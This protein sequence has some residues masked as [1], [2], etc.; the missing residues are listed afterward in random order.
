LGVCS[1]VLSVQLYKLPI[2][3]LVLYLEN[4][5]PMH[6]NYVTHLT[7]FFSSVV[8]LIINKFLFRVPGLMPGLVMGVFFSVYFATP[9]LFFILKYWEVLISPSSFFFTLAFVF[10]CPLIM[11]IVIKSNET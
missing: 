7:T 10:L 8:F 11:N 3:K 2:Y 5:V 4:Y 6:A 1:V 9:S